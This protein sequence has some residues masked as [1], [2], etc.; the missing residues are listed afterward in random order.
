MM[1]QWE[2]SKSSRSN[3]RYIVICHQDNS[4]W[5]NSDEQFHEIL[6]NHNITMT[7]KFTLN[8]KAR[9][10]NRNQ[11]NNRFSWHHK[12]VQNYNYFHLK[13]V[14]MTI[15]KKY[16]RLLRNSII[17][18]IFIWFCGTWQLYLFY[19]VKNF[20]LSIRTKPVDVEVVS[21]WYEPLYTGKSDHSFLYV[22][23]DCGFVALFR[24]TGS[25][26]KFNWF[27]YRFQIK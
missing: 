15:D 20:R 5:F 1:M 21:K 2:E 25:L 6:T 22:N 9:W 11:K 13:R 8:V 19:K 18:H 14:T 7:V 4:D 3:Q 12:W 24:F 16:I 17:S 27:K 23:R 26:K 10:K